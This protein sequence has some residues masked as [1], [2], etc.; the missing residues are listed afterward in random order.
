MNNNFGGKKEVT[1]VRESLGSAEAVIKK[2]DEYNDS[3]I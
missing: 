1:I 3:Y 2:P